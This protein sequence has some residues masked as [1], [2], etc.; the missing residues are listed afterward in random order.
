M[1]RIVV[2]AMCALLAAF[3]PSGAAGSPDAETERS[4]YVVVLDPDSS[5]S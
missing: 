5:R 4:S 3:A 1:T 2:A